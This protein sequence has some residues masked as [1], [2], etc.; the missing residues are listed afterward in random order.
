M[1]ESPNR[2]YVLGTGKLRRKRQAVPVDRH[3]SLPGAVE[4]V[5][6]RYF[7]AVRALRPTISGGFEKRR[8]FAQAVARR[9]ARRVLDARDLA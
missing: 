6:E 5:I 9:L 7:E 2:R 3:P 8:D 4:I 1:L